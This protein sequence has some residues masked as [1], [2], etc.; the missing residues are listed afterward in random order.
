MMRLFIAINFDQQTVDQIIAVQHRLRLL[1]T[2][3]FSRPENLHL[4]LAFLGEVAPARIA[5]I[6]DAMDNT[7]VLPMALTFDHVG[8]FKR[9][10]GDIWW[11]GLQENASLLSLQQALAGHLADAGF[12]IERRHFSPHITL[13]REVR[14]T[15]RPDRSTL[16]KSPFTARV[17][18]ISLMRSERIGGRLTY[19]ELYQKGQI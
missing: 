16:L 13:A 17:G 5:A 7:T 14:L 6:H 12:L 2:G 9:D 3:N 18:A 1:G 11:I 10:G 4:T 19:T 15:A 8:C